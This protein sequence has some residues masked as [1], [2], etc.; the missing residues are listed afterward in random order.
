MKREPRAV[1]PLRVTL[2]RP[3]E[4]PRPRPELSLTP[5]QRQLGADGQLLR[6]GHVRRRALLPGLRPRQQELQ[7]R[8]RLFQRRQQ[9]ERQDAVA[10]LGE[11]LQQRVLGPLL[12]EGGEP[13]THRRDGRHDQVHLTRASPFVEIGA[14]SVSRLVRLGIVRLS[15]GPGRQLSAR[16]ELTVV[17]IRL[18]RLTHAVDHGLVDG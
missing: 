9:R 16:R 6:E 3:R 10:N 14:E 1:R 8:Q 15:L 17:K 4:Q 11:L 12:E 13:P 7:A 2:R 18:D 5:T